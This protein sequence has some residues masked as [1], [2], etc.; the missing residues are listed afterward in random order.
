M[1]IELYFYRIIFL[2]GYIDLISWMCGVLLKVGGVDFVMVV[3]LMILFFW[4]I[5][6]FLFNG[7]WRSEE[8]VIYVI[9]GNLLYI[10]CFR[11]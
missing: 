4:I 8:V 3:I 9:F 11:E 10:R 7:F 6:R 1:L 2:W 5:N